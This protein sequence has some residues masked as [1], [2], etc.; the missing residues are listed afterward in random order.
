MGFY[1]EHAP[2]IILLGMKSTTLMMWVEQQ[3]ATLP[4]TVLRSRT[5]L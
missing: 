1:L 5:G 2:E 3:H 4:D